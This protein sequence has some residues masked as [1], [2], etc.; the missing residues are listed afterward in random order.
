MT[1]PAWRVGKGS[2]THNGGMALGEPALVPCM[3]AGAS[4]AYSLVRLVSADS[5]GMVPDSVLL[6]SILQLWMWW[7]RTAQPVTT[8]PQTHCCMWQ[9][10]GVT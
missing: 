3:E 9:V 1:Q 6:S 10:V 4:A 5:S 2:L 7:H 8:T